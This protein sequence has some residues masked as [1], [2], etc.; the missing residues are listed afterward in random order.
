VR[1]WAA[2]KIISEYFNI[3]DSFENGVFNVEV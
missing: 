1:D 3:I 2:G